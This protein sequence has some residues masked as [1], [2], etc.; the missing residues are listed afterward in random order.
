MSSRDLQRHGRIALLFSSFRAG[1]IERVM[2]NLAE[3][4][5]ARGASVDLVVMSARG[6][7][8]SLVPKGANV[9][10]LESGRA[11][12]SLSRIVEYLRNRRPDALLASQT[13][14]NLVAIWA[15]AWARIPVRLIVS[16]HIAADAAAQNGSWKERWFPTGARLFY[17]KADGL[18]AVSHATADRFAAATGLPRTMARVIYNPI[19]TPTLIAQATSELDHPWFAQSE[20]P[21]ILSVGRLTRQKD[22][23]T[24]VRAFALLRKSTPA[25]LVV[26]GEGAER[27]NLERL[28]GR[29]GLEREVQLPGFVLNPFAYMARAQLFALSSRWEGLPSVLVEAMACGAPVVST[30][31]PT[32]PAE[33]LKDGLF[34]R[35]TPVGDAEALADAMLRTLKDPPD[36]GALRA[37]GAEFSRNR[38]V[39]QY[40]DALLP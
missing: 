33:I 11:L 37:R 30:D 27:P 23:E 15:R 24:L 12:R 1:G 34:G 4:F 35:L 25:R 17:R 31:C 26:L 28:I 38:A 8:E 2:L 36:A 18:V 20:P 3:G 39:E 9:V 10:D 16:E 13:H 22:H 7:L 6:D 19:V 40:L 5:L 32:G 29:L 14:L 21:V